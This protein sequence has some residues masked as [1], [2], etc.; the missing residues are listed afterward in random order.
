MVSFKSRMK[1]KG[2]HLI[3][4]ATVRQARKAVVS[5]V[6]CREDFKV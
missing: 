2:V 3:V 4:L 6:K 5:K 1:I